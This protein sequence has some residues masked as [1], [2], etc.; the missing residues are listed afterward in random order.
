MTADSYPFNVLL[1]YGNMV[2]TGDSNEVIISDLNYI[3]TQL[4]EE[5]ATALSD[6]IMT[7]I[8]EQ[9]GVA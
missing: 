1:D 5:D 4:P 2:S 3:M 6:S 7:L 9:V 8:S